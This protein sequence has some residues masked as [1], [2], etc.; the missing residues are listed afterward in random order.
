MSESQ[1]RLSERY[2]VFEQL[3]AGPS[4]TVWRGRDVLAGTEHAVKVL[5][6]ELLREPEAVTRFY[7]VLG[8]VARLPHPGIVAAQDAVPGDGW[9]ALIS[10]LVPGESLRSLLFRR[11]VLSP[12]QAT[13]LGAQLYDALA[14]AHAAGLA[15]GGLTATNVL[16]EPGADAFPAARLTDFGIAAL[17]GDAALA[18]AGLPMVPPAE[19][20]A[21]ELA[22][23]QPGTAAADV[24]A[25]GVLLYEALAGRPPFSAPTPAETAEL[26]RYAPPPPIAGLPGALWLPLADSLEKDPWQRPTAAELA[27][28]LRAA[29]GPGAAAGLGSIRPAGPVAAPVAPAAPAGPAAPP[30][31]AVEATRMMP[32]VSPQYAGMT[33]LTPHFGTWQ[34]GA[35]PAPVPPTA[36]SRTQRLVR[37]HR[38]ELGIAAAVAV[39]TLVVVSFLALNGGGQANAASSS[40]TVATTASATPSATA[41]PSMMAV[42]L[43]SG[44]PSSP[45]ASPSAGPSVGSYGG[46][47]LANALSGT[48]LHTRGA[49]YTDGTIEEIS[50]C[51]TD[52]SQSWTLSSS[53]QLTQ[54]NGAFCLDD[55]G[56]GKTPGTAVGLWSCNGG[57]NQQW[58]ILPSGLIVG[59]NSGL[60]VDLTNQA[61]A[62][63]T[64][65]VLENCDSRQPSQQW[66]WH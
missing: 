62:D 29:A 1:W 60:C 63:G 16:L 49:A 51:Q 45:S 42:V 43:P 5:R 48:C 64:A 21:P 32:A 12:Q 2:E 14:A 11:G 8:S 33:E 3:G 34:S 25:V 28:E 31:V 56:F 59:V 18:D 20:L 38:V 23:A 36:E 27:E 13:L 9:L 19:Y 30:A 15:H 46:T 58:T 61:T 44:S 57:T 24:Y 52:P 55:F 35:E 47:N 50:A 17:A 10:R 66:S 53:G 39:C 37:E 6:P 22:P 4:G 40:T 41:S 26:H 54:N 7:T 65:L